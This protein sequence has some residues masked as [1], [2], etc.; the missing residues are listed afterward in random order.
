MVSTWSGN[1]ASCPLLR[2]SGAWRWR[3]KFAMAASKA[4]SR[5]STR[6]WTGSSAGFRCWPVIDRGRFGTGFRHGLTTTDVD[7]ENRRPAWVIVIAWY[8]ELIA[9]LRFP[10]FYTDRGLR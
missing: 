2:G 9:P 1:S 3:P 6:W 7:F 5:S 10:R 8:V 4:E